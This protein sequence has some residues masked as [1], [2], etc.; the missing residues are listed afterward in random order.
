M[1]TRDISRALRTVSL[2]AN[3][4]VNRLVSQAK[5][6]KEGY[7]GKK[8]AE[9]NIALD[10]LNAVTGD[11]AKKGRG[12]LFGVSKAKTRNEM[13]SQISDI[14]K[15]MNMKSSTIKGAVKLRKEREERLFGTSVEKA[16][17]GKT[18]KQKQQIKAEFA[19]MSADAY[20]VYRKYLEHEGIPNSPYMKFAGSDVVLETIGKKILSGGNEEEALRAAI[21]SAEDEYIK[22]QDEMFEAI[23]GEDY[24]EL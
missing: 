7:V 9:Y 13:I 20:R 17:K 24:F 23:D 10:A 12:N 6:T 22:Q 21:Q 1:D 5:K 18:K 19:A 11:G 8:S 4:R 16:M 14:R 3:K 2:A 15:F